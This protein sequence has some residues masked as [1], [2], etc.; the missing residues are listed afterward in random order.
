MRHR[1]TILFLVVACTTAPAVTGGGR[2]WSAGSYGGRAYGGYP[3][4]YAPVIIY[5][6]PQVQY[7]VIGGGYRGYTVYPPYGYGGYGR[8][9]VYYGPAV[10]YRPGYGG[11]CRY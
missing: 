11:G 8:P 6:R 4:P 10:G 3:Q 1:I 5:P 2:H 7:G 9:G